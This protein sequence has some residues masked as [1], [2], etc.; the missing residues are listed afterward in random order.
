MYPLFVWVALDCPSGFAGA[1]PGTRT[2]LASMT[3]ELEASVYPDH[4]NIVTAWPIAGK[5]R[6]HRAASAIHDQG[7]GRVAVAETLWI[8]IRAAR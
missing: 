8:T 6:K 4:A 1:P 3:A 5:R 7:G 2:V